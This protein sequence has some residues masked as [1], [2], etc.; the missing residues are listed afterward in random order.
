[1]STV[2]FG[3]DGWR[4]EIAREFTVANLRRVVQAICDRF[5]RTG[6]RLAV[7]GFD[8]RFQSPRFAEEAAGVLLGNELEVRMSDRAEPTPAV[9]CQVVDSGA[10]FGVVITASHNPPEFQGLKIKTSA[11]ASAPPELT[12]EVE[13]LLDRNPVRFLPPSRGLGMGRLR[14]GP[15]GP[16]H[17]G[18]MTRM[19][20]LPRIRSARLQVAVDSMHGTGGRILERLLTDGPT[21]VVTLRGDPDPQ[22]G[23]G[24]PEPT[25]GRLAPLLQRVAAGGFSLG[26][27]TDGDAD[28]IAAVDEAGRFV[29]PL[30][31]IGV[32]ALH[33]VRRRKIPGAIAKTF[34]NT[35]YLDRI[36]SAESRPFHCFPV[37]FKHIAA[38]LERGELAI[39]GEESG[40]IGFA[41]YL[42]ERDGLLAGL[43]LLE[44]VA[45]AGTTLGSLVDAMVREFGDYHYDRK[46]L[47]RP[48]GAT[49]EALGRLGESPPDEVAGLTVRGIDPLD[50]LKLLLG[51]EG[52]LLLR[53][54]GT[55][56][57]LRIYAEARSAEKVDALLQAGVELVQGRGPA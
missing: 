55:E 52:W 17:L 37:G 47:A 32:L 31:L 43:M 8:C 53:A 34:A 35:I 50:G 44:A 12:R 20:D 46:D 24:A 48:A 49:Q 9:S 23:G 30:R 27:G 5:S 11:G 41:G 54:S 33:V 45:M 3:T 39:G 10:D 18:R 28:R 16:A 40:G 2:R 21:R 29:S 36:A 6:A 57:V 4:A 56:P 38:L 25:R 22:F 15:F 1:M 19:V 13:D 7:V 51:E 42:P 14:I 26:L